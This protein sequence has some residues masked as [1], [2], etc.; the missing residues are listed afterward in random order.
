[1]PDSARYFRLEPMMAELADICNCH[2]TEE[3]VLGLSPVDSDVVVGSD[4]VVLTR[5]RC[6]PARGF[7]A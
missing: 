6:D 4:A 3:V 7:C 1:M 2:P 5:T